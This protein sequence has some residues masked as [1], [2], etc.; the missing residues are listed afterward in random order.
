MTQLM[1]ESV[2][3]GI[4]NSSSIHLKLHKEQLMTFQNT[5]L[6]HPELHSQEYVGVLDI[7]CLAAWTHHPPYP[8]IPGG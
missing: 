2:N 4:T 6:A 5:F 7:F 3:D 1:M 8:V